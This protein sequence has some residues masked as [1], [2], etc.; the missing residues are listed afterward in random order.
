MSGLALELSGFSAGYGRRRIVEDA[1]IEPVRPG[2][3]LALVGPNGAGKSTLLKALAGLADA[4]GT[5]RLGT[6]DLLSRAARGRENLVGFMPQTVPR[7]VRLSVFESVVGAVKAAP[8]AREAL[9]LAEAE[10]RA[11]ETLEALGLAEIA[12]APL[13]R[14][15]GGQRQMASFAQTVVRA[16][17]LLLLDEPTSALD[18]RHQRELMLAARAFADAGRIVAVVLH[19]LNLALR[20][21]DR[22]LV[23]HRGRLRA[24]GPPATVLTPDLVAEVYGV[25]SRLEA[26][27]GG[28]PYLVVD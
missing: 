14:L 21:A 20:W 3:L 7:G 26:G 11:A 16:P 12:H 9:G 10:Q 4:S 13:D 27:S 8:I 5:A 25:A 17:A 23:L 22:L 2:S 28:R 18:L 15:S 1:T 19:D 6:A 24:Q